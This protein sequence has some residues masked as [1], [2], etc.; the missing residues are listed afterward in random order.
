MN[1]KKFVFPGLVC[2]ITWSL[3]I[4]AQQAAKLVI[5]VGHTADIN[6][7]DISP[8]GRYF[9][10][11]SLDNTV[12]IWDESGLEIRTLAGHKMNVRAVAF[13]PLTKADP[14]GGMHILT[15]SNDYTAILWD[16]FGHELAKFTEP[17]DKNG[18]I[19]S[20]AFAP[21]GTAMLVGSQSGNVWLLNDT[22]K[23]LLKFPHK[24]AVSAVAFSP[25]GDYII[26]ACSNQ[27]AVL[28]K[29][30]DAGAPMRVFSHA[31]A[32]TAVV[33]STSGDTILTGC[34]DG[35]ASLWKINGD[36]IR[37]FQHA[38]EVQ[39]VGMS[40]DGRLVATGSS[41]GTLVV[42]KLTDQDAKPFKIF[43]RGLKSLKFTPDG[44]RI[45]CAS[46]KKPLAKLCNLDGRVLKKLKGYTSAITSMALSP[47]GTSLLVGHADSTAKLWDLASQKVRCFPY[48]ARVESVTFSPKN[49]EDAEGGKFILTGCDDRVCRMQDQSGNLVGAPFAQANRA[50]FSNDGQA[51]LTGNSDGT[52]K[53]WNLALK[54]SRLLTH[55]ERSVTSLAFSPVPGSKAFAIGSSDGGVVYWDSAGAQPV[56]FKLS[57]PMPVF[58]MAFAPDGQTIV[59][60]QQG[61]LTEIRDLSGTL[62]KEYPNRKRGTQNVRSVTFSPPNAS[63]KKGGR[64]VLRT[65]G[66]NVERWDWAKSKVDTLSGHTAE[67]VAV[68]FTSD[69]S[70]CFTASKDG[71]VKYWNVATGKEI[72]TLVSIDSTD[73][74][75][76]SPSGLFD[77]STYATKL[78]HFTTGM[79]VIS[80]KQINERY[81]EPGLLAKVTGFSSDS[82][83]NVTR[84]DSLSLFPEVTMNLNGNKLEVSI[85]ERNGGIGKLSLF[86]N[87]KRMIENIN[88][89][90]LKTLPP[91][92][93]DTFLNIYRS[94]IPNTIGLVSYNADNVLRSQPYERIYQPFGARGEEDENAGSIAAARNNCATADPHIYLIIVGTSKYQDSTINLA[95]PDLDAQAMAKALSDVGLAMRPGRVHL[96][97]LS[98]N[99]GQG[100]E[101]AT[102]A[103]I[104]ASFE[105]FAKE[106]SPCDVLLA[107]FSGHG[108]NWAPEE[109]KRAK[110]YYLTG[111][112]SSGKLRDDALR[113]AHAISDAELET[114]LTNVPAEKQ[115]L[116]LD[117]CHSGAAAE[118]LKGI[119]Q[120]NLNSN[121]A[122]ALKLLN[123]RTGT[124]ILSGSMADS[125]SYEASKF[126]Q[127]LLTYSLL[128]GMNGAG[129]NRKEVDVDKL[130]QYARNEVP[131]LAESIG[132]T[133]TPV[134]LGEGESFPIGLNDGSIDI[135]LPQPKD[136][137]IPS[138]FQSRKDILDN[139]KLGEALNDYFYEQRLKG[140]QAK[141]VYYETSTI[142]SHGYRVEG[143][144][145]ENGELVTIYAN[146][147]KG[148]QPIG[149]PFELKGTKD[150]KML[151]DLILKEIKPRVGKHN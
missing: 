83:R 96:K 150:T 45:L 72:A 139:L 114:W 113:N 23:P 49:R 97:V 27:T 61:G 55:T 24:G 28:W 68:T 76:T 144:Y 105:Q 66:N 119:G 136:V 9:L 78:M 5:P 63:D 125:K 129:L 147:F 127:G 26:T 138:K 75:V 142:L 2:L 41:N 85:K 77:A 29:R 100:V 57:M 71:T 89:K 50:L 48:K 122:I 74:A 117:A 69:G 1:A 131:K 103:N 102:K 151:V 8:N 25:K 65:S 13:S 56:S 82:V 73:W 18:E 16:K 118:N 20:V 116:I 91:I 110:F 36:K 149:Q 108:K 15:G 93:L 135:K 53:I 11:G 22:L 54:Q 94:D 120:R 43:D 121:Q 84:I 87:K 128:S 58:A 140:T 143:S 19:S 6:A 7:V 44:Q 38:I 14:E 145:E 115:V 132:Q 21:E 101:L 130:F 111:G 81:Y 134:L 64:Y 146:L 3:P 46:D 47:D 86:V 133:Q 95:Y 51:V 40:P 10:T 107:Y 106:A 109:G 98:T 137:F 92:D 104:K 99:P 141:Y 80:F 148:T 124:W 126:G 34:A 35:T 17:S 33:F 31:A 60:G 112:I 62:I 59:S 37:S 30:S 52:L 12:K 123:D 70:A 32:V 90:K 4:D 67:V 42:W 39:S 88:P 79:D